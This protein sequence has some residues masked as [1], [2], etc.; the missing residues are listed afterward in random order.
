FLNRLS[1]KMDLAKKSLEIGKT[2]KIITL[3]NTCH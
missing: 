1:E 3:K 2:V